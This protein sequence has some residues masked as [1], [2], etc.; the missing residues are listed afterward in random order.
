VVRLP[1]APDLAGGVRE[2]G[3]PP[4]LQRK[5]S[6]KERNCYDASMPRALVTGAAG[7]IASSTVDRLLEAGWHVVGYDNFDPYYDPAQKR[8]NIAI[9]SGHERYRFVEGDVRDPAALNGAFR[10]SSLDAVV[11]L[12]ARP[13]VRAS[14]ENPRLYAEVNE[15]GGLNV[16]EACVTHGNVPLVYA[17]TSSVYGNSAAVPFRED[18]PAIDPLSPYAASKRSGELMARTFHTLHKLPT[19][20]VR[21][22][23]VYGPRGRP[24]M[25]VHKFTELIDHGKPIRLHGESTARD[26]TYIDDIVSGIIG[27][28]SWLDRGGAFDTF[29]LGNSDP[30]LART[31]IEYLGKAIG[32]EPDVILTHLQPGES[33]VTC[34]DVSKAAAAFD[35]APRVDLREGVARW[36]DWY[37]TSAESP[38]AANR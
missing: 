1:L 16:L 27:S 10:D 3:A 34:A 18:D 31:L 37:R 8:R 5:S 26:F 13:G 38:L 7:F 6:A 9:A 14:I 33:S 23:T 35:Y 30:V 36:L 28:L 19:A 25:A 32:R 4:E 17:S 20:I 15:I 12:A 22:F 24:D 21:F 2:Q 29:N 11:H